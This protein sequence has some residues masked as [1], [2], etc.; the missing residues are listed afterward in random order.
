MYGGVAGEAGQPVPLCR[1]AESNSARPHAVAHDCCVL[2]SMHYLWST[3]MGCAT[4]EEPYE[5]S[6]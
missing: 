5:T 1:F 2:H 6:H 3:R 4:F